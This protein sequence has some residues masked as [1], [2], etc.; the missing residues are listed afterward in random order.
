MPKPPKDYYKI[1]Q[2]DLV[3]QSIMGKAVYL[4]EQAAAEQ[5]GTSRTVIRNVFSRLA[6]KG[7]LEHIPR[8]GWKLRP[9]RQQDMDAFG[10][11]RVA[12]ELLALK[13][14]KTRLV[15]EDLR[16]M[17]DNHWLPSTEHEQPKT[18]NSLHAYLV[19]KA[20]NDYIRDF[21]DRHG[22]YYLMLFDEELFSREAAIDTVRQHQAILQ[23]LIAR[24]WDVAA[25][26]LEAHLRYDYTV[27]RE[28]NLDAH[29]P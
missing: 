19:D 12:M 29:L 18:D 23:A 9:L 1:I 7:L 13:L 11:V 4:R 17:L 16:R 22:W 8:R 14:A 10:E 26:A 20:D 27:L 24:D 2:E 21:F 28:M 3:G 6:G 5:Y 15:E 25:K